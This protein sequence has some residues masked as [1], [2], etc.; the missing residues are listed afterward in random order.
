MRS[1]PDG[2]KAAWCLAMTLGYGA[3][4]L[5]TVATGQTAPVEARAADADDAPGWR[6]AV[7]PYLWMPALQG[8][9]ALEGESG[10]F[11][12]PFHKAMHNLDFF[13]L[14]GV[15][16]SYGPY[17]VF[18]DAQ[19]L[20]VSKRMTFAMPGIS[21]DASMRSTQVSLGGSY[22]AYAQVLGGNTVFGAP[23]QFTVAPMAG[24]HWTRLNAR[25][26]GEGHTLGKSTDWAI[27]FVGGRVGYD[28][29]PHWT[30]TAEGDVGAWGRDWG[31]QGQTYL[32]YRLGLWGQE[33][34]LRVGYRV[35]HQD[36]QTDDLHW[37]VTQYGPAAGL[38]VWF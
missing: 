26:W 21:A 1:R 22:Q 27:P 38:T 24:V 6:F 7:T 37:N 15:S 4:A 35:I 3:P 18:L 20:D 32:G 8:N 36:H 12:L 33:S 34:L 30:L 13:T 2:W 16:A 9:G 17:S 25:V 28:L 29:D 5:A 23:Q 31:L 11:T 10:R 14:G 19:Y